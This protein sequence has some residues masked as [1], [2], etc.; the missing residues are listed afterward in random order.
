MSQKRDMGHHK[1]MWAAICKVQ[2]L[3][4][5]MISRHCSKLFILAWMFVAIHLVAQTQYSLAKQEI[6]KQRLDF[7][8]G[9]DTKREAALMQLFIQVG[10][11]APHLSEQPVPSRKQPNVICV[12][13]GSTSETIV[14]GAH[15]DHVEDGDGV[16]D[17]WSGASLLPSL[18]QSLSGSPRRHTFIF[19]GFTGEEEGLVGSEY[20]VQQLLPDQISKIEAMINMDTLALGPTKVWVTQSDPRLVNAIGVVAQSMK[21][22][23]AAMNVDGVGESD[24]ESFIG[25]KVCTL[26]VHS[27]T[28]QTL[29]ILHHTADNPSALHFSDYYDTYHLLAAYLAV[30]DTR[31]APEGH[32]CT[33]K[34]K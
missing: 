7:Y 1:E 14:V 13:P 15:F 5:G 6:V 22:P 23:I 12:L 4:R 28:P 9:N 32:I 16:V 8:K 10:C 30:L 2:L 33:A 19:V 31:F 11:T 20:Y 25:K 29:H 34:P 18:F 3:S 27:L 17:N 26:T 24:E 21:L